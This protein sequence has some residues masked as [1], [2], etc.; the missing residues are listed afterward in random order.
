[1]FA[2]LSIFFVLYCFQTGFACEELIEERAPIVQNMCKKIENLGSNTHFTFIDLGLS[3][4]DLA[5]IDQFKIESTKQ[6]DRFGSL[7]LLKEELPAFLREIGKGDED[8]IQRITNIIFEIA[9]NIKNACNKETA[10]VC[11]RASLPNH[12]FDEP[13]WHTDGY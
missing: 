8:V 12:A 3:S 9:C 6:Y 10:W 4:E 13:R 1:M 11:V 5:L 2:R 7:Y